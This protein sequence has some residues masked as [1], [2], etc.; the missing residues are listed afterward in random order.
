[1]SIF[2]RRKLLIAKTANRQ[3]QEGLLL[4]LFGE[5]AFKFVFLKVLNLERG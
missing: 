4:L 2:R 5:G 3:D 1:M